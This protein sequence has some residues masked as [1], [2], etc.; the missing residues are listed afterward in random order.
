M[1]KE[2]NQEKGNLGAEGMK[3]TPADGKKGDKQESLS[4]EKEEEF[5]EGGLDKKGDGKI[6]ITGKKGNDRGR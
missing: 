2:A 1:W 6:R 5:R 3:G 4:K